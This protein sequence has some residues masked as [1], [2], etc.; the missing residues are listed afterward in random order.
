M[1]RYLGLKMSSRKFRLQNS[2]PIKLYSH[3]VFTS[4]IHDSKT[5]ENVLVNFGQWSHVTCSKR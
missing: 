1:K 2:I 5:L 4:K 3:K